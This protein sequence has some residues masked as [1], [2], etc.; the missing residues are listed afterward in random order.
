MPPRFTINSFLKRA[1]RDGIVRHHHCRAFALSISLA[2][3]KH[4]RLSKNSAVIH[5]AR[6]TA[7]TSTSFLAHVIK[8]I[9]STAPKQVIAAHARRIIAVM[10][11]EW[12]IRWRGTIVN[13]TGK[14]VCPNPRLANRRNNSEQPVTRIRALAD[15]FPTTQGYL[16]VT[17]K[18]IPEAQVGTI[19]P[20]LVALITAEALIRARYFCKR[21]AAVLADAWYFKCSQGVTSRKV[22]SWTRLVRAFNAS[23]RAVLHYTAETSIHRSEI[24]Q[25]CT[26]GGDRY[27]K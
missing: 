5:F 15:P 11:G 6:P 19:S 24:M 25:Y 17:P 7:T 12:F 9:F 23:A 22:A 18:S 2:S 4:H 13:R 21:V 16:E 3:V 8:V 1:E 27:R 20:A 14:N 26:A 10:T